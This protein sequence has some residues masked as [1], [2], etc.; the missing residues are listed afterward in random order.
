MIYCGK[1]LIHYHNIVYCLFGI[2]YD[3]VKRLK[4][5]IQSFISNILWQQIYVIQQKK[6]FI[7]ISFLLDFFV[8]YF[9]LIAWSK[10]VVLCAKT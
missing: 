1:L 4:H 8:Y 10:L 6:F 5:P 9:I 3:T 2:V 7:K